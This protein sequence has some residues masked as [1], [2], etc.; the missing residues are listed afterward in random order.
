MTGQIVKQAV[1]PA[2]ASRRCTDCGG[3]GEIILYRGVEDGP[4]ATC[5]TPCALCGGHG[6]LPAEAVRD[7][8]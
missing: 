6:W 7:A 2:H 4:L 1:N 5:S 3:S 8:H